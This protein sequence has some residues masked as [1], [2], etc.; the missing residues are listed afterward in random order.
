M[1]TNCLSKTRRKFA[2]VKEIA[3]QY[4]VTVQDIYKKLKLPIFE[5]AIIK[6]GNRG[7]R[8]DQDK[9]YEILERTYR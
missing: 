9:Y 4:S 7:I 2:T 8:V 5:E 1:A 6:I 3:E